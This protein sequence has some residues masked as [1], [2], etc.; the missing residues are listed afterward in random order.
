MRSGRATR[1]RRDGP[2]LSCIWGRVRFG[3]LARRALPRTAREELSLRSL[4]SSPPRTERPA[5][6]CQGEP[7]R[8]LADVVCTPRPPWPAS[9]RCFEATPTESRS[10]SRWRREHPTR[11]GALVAV[12][13]AAPVTP[14][15]TLSAEI[16]SAAVAIGTVA[17]AV[18]M[19]IDRRLSLLSF[20][21]RRRPSGGQ[22]SGL[23]IL[24]VQTEPRCVHRI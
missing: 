2:P 19:R 17:P 21:A 1:W 23:V 13:N 12:V 18:S 5:S 9:M 24:W 11:I 20:V 15:V 6:A 16:T 4:R 8:Y 22:N 7:H 14:A 10:G 3:T